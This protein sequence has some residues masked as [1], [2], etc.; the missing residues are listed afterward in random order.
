IPLS[1]YAQQHAARTKK[2]FFQHGKH[3]LANGLVSHQ[4]GIEARN[5]PIRFGHA[6]FHVP[7][8]VG[9]NRELAPHSPQKLP[10][11]GAPVGELL[12]GMAY[13]IP[14]GH[15]VPAL[16]PA[17]YP[18]YGAQVVQ[19]AALAPASWPGADAGLVQLIN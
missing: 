1:G 12:K 18:R 8:Q 4:S 11:T 15:G 2:L 13:S 7:H 19:T 10:M 9:K 17:E 5:I 6:Q 3:S 16:H 14:R